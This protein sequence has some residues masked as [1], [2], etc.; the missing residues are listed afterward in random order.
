MP[1]TKK[2]IIYILVLLI[3][4][5]ASNIFILKNNSRVGF[6][7]D[8][9]NMICHDHT[10]ITIYGNFYK[11][12]SVDFDVSQLIFSAYQETLSADGYE[13][14]RI[15]SNE[16]FNGEDAPFEIVDYWDFGWGVSEGFEEQFDLIN[17]K[18]DLDYIFIAKYSGPEISKL[19]NED[20][21]HLTSLQTQRFE[22]TGV[23]RPSTFHVFD[24]TTKQFTYS[25]SGPNKIQENRV[26]VQNTQSLSKTDLINISKS[27]TDNA[28]VSAQNMLINFQ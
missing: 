9:P 18:Y 11:Y 1:Y 19:E 15:P 21:C 24:T 3:S 17:K 16:Y 6:V 7:I 10:G 26:R 2:I 27:I 14:I 28:K 20:R 5:C 12:Y 8:Y 4:G 22:K 25:Y 13:A 23:V